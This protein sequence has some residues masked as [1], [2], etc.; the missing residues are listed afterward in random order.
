MTCTSTVTQSTE[1]R[2]AGGEVGKAGPGGG[3]PGEA[4]GAVRV[5]GPV[6]GCL[7]DLHRSA[8]LG[9][10]LGRAGQPTAH[11]A[12]RPAETRKPRN[13]PQIEMESDPHVL[14]VPRAASLH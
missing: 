2:K 5:R 9:L 7:G 8:G 6:H 1:R 3:V 4:Q 10:G 12:R 13:Q 14:Q 11:V